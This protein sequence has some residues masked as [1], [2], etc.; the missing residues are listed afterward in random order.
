MYSFITFFVTSK[1]IYLQNSCPKTEPGSDT[2]FPFV[3]ILGSIEGAI[4]TALQLWTTNASSAQLT[5][6]GRINGSAFIITVH[7]NILLNIS[8]VTNLCCLE[9][10]QF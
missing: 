2:W 1:V 8:C 7:M 5:D 10:H 4:I 6:L 3:L 9:R